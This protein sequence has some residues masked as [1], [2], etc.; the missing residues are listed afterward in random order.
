[1]ICTNVGFT[2]GDAVAPASLAQAVWLIPLGGCCS[3]QT[4]IAGA[5]AL[6]LE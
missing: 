5:Q 2:L 4:S 6:P 3:S 1:M